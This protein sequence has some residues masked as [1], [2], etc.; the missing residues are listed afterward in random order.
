MFLRVSHV[1]R[2]LYSTVAF[3]LGKECQQYNQK[4]ARSGAT[5]FVIAAL[6][7]IIECSCAGEGENL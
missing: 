3:L 6:G 2:P 7:D 4:S 1:I 5:Q